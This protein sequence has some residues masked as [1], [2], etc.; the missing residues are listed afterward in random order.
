MILSLS[1][2]NTCSF[3]WYYSEFVEI[4]VSHR[5]FAKVIPHLDFIKHMSFKVN[6]ESIP[7]FRFAGI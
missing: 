4:I 5:D 6:K 1:K 2:Q 7:L 3:F